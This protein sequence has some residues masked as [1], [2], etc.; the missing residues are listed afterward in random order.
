MTDMGNF[1]LRDL[2][3]LYY[4]KGWTKDRNLEDL[5]SNQIYCFIFSTYL[6]RVGV[7]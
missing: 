7:T 1:N 3:V 4:V 6:R 2:C 5:G